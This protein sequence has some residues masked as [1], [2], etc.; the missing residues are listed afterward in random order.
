MTSSRTNDEVSPCLLRKQRQKAQTSGEAPAQ[1]RL[2]A[3]HDI[4]ILPQARYSAGAGLSE[5]ILDLL[6]SPQYL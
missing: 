1:R 2:S 4:W 3:L 6:A 5:S